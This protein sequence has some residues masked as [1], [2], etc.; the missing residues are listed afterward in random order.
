M[1]GKSIIIESIGITIVCPRLLSTFGKEEL[2]LG[3]ACIKFGLKSERVAVGSTS[4]GGSFN[5]CGEG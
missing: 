3:F 4:G 5:K 2:V 1:M